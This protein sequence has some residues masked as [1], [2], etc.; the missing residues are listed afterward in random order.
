MRRRDEDLDRELR[1]DLELEQEEQRDRGLSQ[2]EARFA[3]LRAFGNP[4][5]LRDQTRAEWTGGWLESLLRDLRYAFRALRRTPGFTSVAITVMAL[6]I[7][8]NV[9]LF[10]VVRGIVLKSLPFADPSRL[11][12]IYESGLHESDTPGYEP[13]AG[14]IYAEWKRL[15]KTFSSLAIVDD[16]LVQLSGSGR[17]LP[18][19]LHCSEFSWDLL[20]TLGVQPALGRN[21]NPADDSPSAQGT[22]LLS[23]PLWQRRFA[24]DPAIVNHT[25]YIDATPYTVIGVMP[26]WFDF[27]H[28]SSQLWLPIHHE[29]S[30][31]QMTSYSAHTLSIIGRLRP[32]V[33]PSQA[34]ADLSLISQNIRNANR[35]DPFI[36]SAANTRTLLDALVG[37]IRRPLLVLLAATFCVLFI[38]CLN[39][40]SLLV[41]RAMARRRDLAVRTALGGGWPRLMRERLLESLL[42]SAFGGALGLGLA[43][44]AL[45]WFV[46]ARPDIVR[47]QT[48]HLDFAVAAFTLAVIA[49]CAVVS[50]LISVFS[51]RHKAILSVLRES[52]RSFAGERA[53]SNLRRMLLA[54][55]LALTVVLLIG[56]G[57]L[58]RSYQRLRASDPGCRISSI[59]TLHTGLPDAHYSTPVLRAAF[60]NTVLDRVRALPGVEAAGFADAVPGQ[61]YLTEQALRI[62]EHPPLA[63]GQ[64]MTASDR[65]ADPGYFQAIGIPILSGRT[66]D[67]ARRLANADEVVVDQTLVNAW[68]PGEDPIGKHILVGGRKD[69]IV[70]VVGP[71]RFTM[72]EEPRPTLYESME[73]GRQPYGQIVVRSSH[74]VAQFALPVQRIIYGIDSDLAVSDILTMD[75]LLG[76]STL[77]PR[78]DATL[79]AIFAVLSL[80]LAAAGLFG[81]LS[82]MVAQRTREIGIRIALG[83]GRAHVLS[84]TLLDG[85]LPAVSGLAI[86]I[87]CGIATTQLLRG[88]LYKTP[89]LDP[90]VFIA[91]AAILLLVAAAACLV[92]AWHASRLDPIQALRTE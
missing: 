24:G 4:A 15:N 21:F 38:A 41:A 58:L 32:G 61:G 82:L 62:V 25:I 47:V 19:K 69:V 72:S 85:L 71:T 36:Y 64:G 86:G 77:G 34:R 73:S 68:F 79:L 20:P 31:A 23:W 48:I 63:Q 81:V 65:I 44:A 13:V 56:A 9:A 84:R 59:L 37:N 75:Q 52:S 67:P 88:M 53:K 27:P 12:M 17:E 14:G 5:A 30:E 92:P 54:A 55:E 46:R 11:L 70:G 7:G 40:S 16:S 87:A 22:V 8:A 78:F 6:G 43:A 90:A 76:G 42:L 57:L 50:G 26:A 39:V 10:T 51:A 91:V 1:S 74:D 49:L 35:S 89:P 18:E 33:S 29:R 45:A 83:A 2:D 66:F 60:Y 80:V 3:A 28:A